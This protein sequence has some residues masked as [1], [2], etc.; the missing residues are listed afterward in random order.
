[1]ADGGGAPSGVGDSAA[2]AEI[3]AAGTSTSAG[4]ADL[5]VDLA[6]T[7][8]ADLWVLDDDLPAPVAGWTANWR[9]V[10]PR[11]AAFCS[12]AL[13]RIGAA[14]RAADVLAHLQDLQQADG[15]FEARYVP[16]TDRAPDRRAPQ[17]DGTGLLLWASAEAVAASGAGGG[18]VADRLAP[19]VTTSLAALHHATSGGIA[20]PPASPDYW[21]VREGAAT[22]WGAGA[23][24]AGLRAGAELTG[25]T[26]AEESAQVFAHLLQGTF[27]RGGWQRYRDGGGADSALAL[28]DATGLHDMIDPARLGA[29]R[30]EL[31]RPAGGIAP[32]AAWKQDGISWTPSTSLLGLGLARAGE[33]LPARE[34]LSWLA[35]HRTEQGSLPEKVLHDGRPAQVAPLAWTAANTLLALDALA[36]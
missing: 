35:A 28:F 7:A 5:L 1:L 24:L 14:D 34:I 21:E 15:W 36:S 3:S 9:Y 18:A 19:L 32:G 12:V 31:S 4:D 2:G 16:G 13:A 22:L 27:G 8:L 29:L 10:W 20:L 26:G 11:D 23:T 6:D 33:H 25:S 17:F 30:S